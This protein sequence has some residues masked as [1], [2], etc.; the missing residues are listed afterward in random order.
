VDLKP[1]TELSGPWSVA[2][3]PAWGPFDAAPGRRPGE[4][5]F[6]RLDDWSQRPED[7]IRYYSGTATYHKVFSAPPAAA[8]RR[9]WLELG[10]V[11]VMAS[12]K[13]NDR[14]LGIVW[15]APWRLELPPGL[16]RKRDNRL[17]VTVANLW[18]NRMI[19][20]ARVSGHVYAQTTHHPFK[21]EH[22]LLPSGLLGPVRL[23]AEANGPG[24]KPEQ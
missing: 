21:A 17:E 3:D 7:A 1:I 12:V 19:G 13:L 11:A 5:I 23:M 22:A 8:G 18:P 2:F 24:P 20:D 15:C 16:L 14:D 10:N 9:L 4:F 6:E